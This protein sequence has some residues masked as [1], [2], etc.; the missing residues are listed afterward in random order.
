MLSHNVYK[1]IY[2]NLT[3]SFQGKGH[4]VIT[5]GTWGDKYFIILKGAVAILL[6]KT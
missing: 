4:E 1:Q 6:P 3:F 5:Y 2:Q